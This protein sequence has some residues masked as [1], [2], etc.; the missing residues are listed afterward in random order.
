MGH[1]SVDVVEDIWL[2]T[3]AGEDD[4]DSSTPDWREIEEANILLNPD[5][6]SMEGRG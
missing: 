4:I 5:V 3:L 1:S 2:N 6:T